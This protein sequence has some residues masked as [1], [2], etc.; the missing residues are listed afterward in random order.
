MTD[1]PWPISPTPLCAA[2]LLLF[3]GSVAY[4][5]NCTITPCANGCPN[6]HCNPICGGNVCAGGCP[7]RCNALV[8][9]ETATCD[10]AC[11]GNPCNINCVC[12]DACSTTVCTPGCPQFDPCSTSCVDPTCT[13]GCPGG[14]LCNDGCVDQ[15]NPVICPGNYCDVACNPAPQCD[16]LCGGNLC[17]DGCP[18]ECNLFLCPQN[19]C[20]LGCRPIA[21]CDPACG[22]NPCAPNC[23][24]GCACPSN[25]C[26]N[27][28]IDYM[29][30]N[31]H[32]HKPNQA[33]IDAVVQMFA[34]QGYTLNVVIDDALTHDDVLVRDPTCLIFF[35]YNLEPNTFGAIKAAN[36]DNAFIP[37]WHYAIFAHDYEGANCQVTGSS[38]LAENPGN[39]LVVTLGQFSGQAG[40]PFDRAA[41]F[42]HEFGHNLGL[43]HCGN[44]DPGGLFEGSCLNVGNFVP[45]VA[46]IMDY[47][48]QLSGVRSNLICQGLAPSDAALFKEIDYSH[49]TMCDLNEGALDENFGTGMVSVDWSCDALVGGV[50][51]KDLNGNA[52]G[53]CG[54][55]GG[56]QLLEDFDEW[57]D[58]AA[59]HFSARNKNFEHMP[60]IECVTA[61]EIEEV[62][63]RGGCAPPTL[64]TEACASAQS[65]YFDASA[66]TSVTGK[67]NAPY[68]DIQAAYNAAPNGSAFFFK[69]GTYTPAAPIVMDKPLKLFAVPTSAQGSAV[70][71]PP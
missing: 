66:G 2:V 46:S 27:V 29:V 16:V 64:A 36:F 19:L 9:L 40:T 43:T 34:C 57:A 62:A 68:K 33:E 14:S 56:L 51:V 8:C 10:P 3:S 49:G 17:N 45:N 53:W 13:P 12:W 65:F 48:Y 52:G 25:N 44:N 69:A 59:N 55:N 28:E 71:Q 18:N 15:C 63:L 1:G 30:D 4:A 6:R 50:V 5:Q 58:I 67:C 11:G 47:F 7:Q 39:D 54:A 61:H 38:G 21:A 23:P 24:T 41:T 32:T 37:G 26:F 42:A 60:M 31:D 20:D 70:I 22:G 35:E